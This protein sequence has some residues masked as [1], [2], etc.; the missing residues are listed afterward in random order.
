VQ[1]APR[2]DLNPKDRN[3]EA[4]S[5]PIYLPIPSPLQIKQGIEVDL[6]ASWII[7]SL[8]AISPCPKLTSYEHS[9]SLP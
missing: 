5:M 9:V 6:M 3:Q 4:K 7:T 1:A 2:N 8:I